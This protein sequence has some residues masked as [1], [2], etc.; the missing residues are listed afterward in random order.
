MNSFVSLG[1]G[2]KIIRTTSTDIWS[3]QA[4]DLASITLNGI[5]ALQS[6]WYSPT[7]SFIVEEQQFV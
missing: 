2:T 7:S 5:T 6:Y 4:L 3:V 1:T